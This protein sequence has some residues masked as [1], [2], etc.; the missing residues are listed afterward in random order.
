MAE[1]EG[2]VD[3]VIDVTRPAFEGIEDF[4]T[5]EVGDLGEVLAA[6]YLED[7]GFEVVDTNWTTPFGEGDI[8]ARTFE[9]IVFVEVKSRRLL[10]MTMDDIDRAAPEEAF[11]IKK[12]ERYAKMAELYKLAGDSA[13]SIRLDVVSITFLSNRIAHISHL[14]GC[15]MWGA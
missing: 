10:G 5:K 11:D 13:E 3:A 14:K 9:E 7:N 4:S 2:R 8:I 15:R 12:F 1:F 6:T